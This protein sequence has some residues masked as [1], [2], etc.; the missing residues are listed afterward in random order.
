MKPESTTD[1]LSELLRRESKK[2]SQKES[3]LKD[4]YSKFSKIWNTSY[5]KCVESSEVTSIFDP[6]TGVC[7]LV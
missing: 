3:L 5:R 7:G 6:L 4:V 2:F 1:Q